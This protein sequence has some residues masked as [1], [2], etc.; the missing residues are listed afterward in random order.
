MLLSFRDWQSRCFELSFWFDQIFILF[1]TPCD[2]YNLCIKFFL[3]NLKFSSRLLKILTLE[4]SKN[5]KTFSIES[6]VAI[7]CS[8]AGMQFYSSCKKRYWTQK[9]L[10]LF[11]T[12]VD[13]N[14]LNNWLH[15]EE[16]LNMCLFLS[17]VWIWIEVLNS[18]SFYAFQITH[19]TLDLFECMGRRISKI[20][21]YD[22]LLLNFLELC[23]Y[24]YILLCWH[25][26][27]PARMFNKGW[28]SID[29]RRRDTS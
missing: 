14:F 6:Q 19:S 12:N 24:W 15:R 7:S 17:S 23:N 25:S 20:N 2:V 5:R 3:K 1:S 29:E 4:Y 16:V 8:A 28:A 26:D 10:M 27:R 13:T 21:I 18:S 11:N 9:C 22:G